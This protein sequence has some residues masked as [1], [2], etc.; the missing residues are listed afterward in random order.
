MAEI[1]VVVVG[2]NKVTYSSLQLHRPAHPAGPGHCA[3]LRLPGSPHQRILLR[4]T[5]GA[6]MVKDQ[7]GH[8]GHRLQQ[9][10]RIGYLQQ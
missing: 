10:G 6:R 4:Q 3:Q 2:Y 1:V 9:N 8:S 7:G 5:R